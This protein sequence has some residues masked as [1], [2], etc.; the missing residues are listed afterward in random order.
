MKGSS[1]LDMGS[2]GDGAT[3]GKCP[4]DMDWMRASYASALE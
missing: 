4:V 2:I 1:P 3:N